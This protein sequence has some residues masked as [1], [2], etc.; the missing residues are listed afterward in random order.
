MENIIL[1][2]ATIAVVAAGAIITSK[3]DASD[4]RA[5][6]VRKRQALT[7]RNYSRLSARRAEL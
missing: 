7:L 1:T 5:A 4:R 2:A 6:K 3:M